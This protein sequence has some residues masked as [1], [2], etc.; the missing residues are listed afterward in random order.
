[1]TQLT[2][3]VS[4]PSF[5]QTAV[6]VDFDAVETEETDFYF[7]IWV[8]CGESDCAVLYFYFLASVF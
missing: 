4:A 7:G 3:L 6:I 5:A 8:C 1:M 2:V